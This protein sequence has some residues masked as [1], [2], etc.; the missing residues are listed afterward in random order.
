MLT[1]LT[2]AYVAY[3]RQVQIAPL[4]YTFNFVCL[5]ARFTVTEKVKGQTCFLLLRNNYSMYGL[6]IAQPLARVLIFYRFI[7]FTKMP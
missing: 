6:G 3:A 4:F 5:S 2:G 1:L 7:G